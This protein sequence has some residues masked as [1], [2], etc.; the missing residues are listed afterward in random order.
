VERKRVGTSKTSEAR[1]KEQSPMVAVV[2][3]VMMTEK[4]KTVVM[5]VMSMSFDDNRRCHGVGGRRRN[6]D[7]WRCNKD[8]R[9]SRYHGNTLVVMSESFEVHLLDHDVTAYVHGRDEIVRH[10]VVELRNVMTI[11]VDGKMMMLILDV[12]MK[13][14][15]GT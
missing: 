6:H 15:A 13:V 11:H 7:G 9:R 10:A 8:G 1:A 3:M 12:Q 4:T 2:V 14:L 5:M